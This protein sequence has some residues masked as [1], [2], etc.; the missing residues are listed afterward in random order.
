MRTGSLIA[1][2]GISSL[3][4]SG[5]AKLEKAEVV[6]S[7]GSG[8]SVTAGTT[9]TG[10]TGNTSG[11]ST[12]QSNANGATSFVFNDGAFVI[13]GGSKT[14]VTVT[15]SGGGINVETASVSVNTG[16]SEMSWAD[17]IEMALFRQTV[18]GINTDGISKGTNFWGGGGG[19]NPSFTGYKE[20][21][22]ITST[23][24][25]ELQ[26]WS[27]NHSSISQYTVFNDPSASNNNNVAVFFDGNATPTS[28]LPAG[29]ATY[30]GKF[31]GTAVASNWLSPERTVNDPFDTD[32]VIGETWDPNGTWRVVGDVSVTANFGAGTVNGSV[33]NTTWRKFTGTSTS[34]DGY[35]TITPQESARPFVNYTFNGTITDNTYSGNVQ[36]PAGQVVNG[37]NAVH[38]GFFGPNAE[39]TAGVIA[40][41]TTAPDP[42][43][44][45]SNNESNRRGYIT[46]RG[47]FQGTR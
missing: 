17:T 42:S 26:V 35:I 13:N 9:E 19:A 11:T 39:E 18:G 15:N 6:T 24:D 27:F 21:R 28:A 16:F 4:L 36:G 31:G 37:N 10:G 45:L 1:I 29:S 33:T 5:C 34:P 22:K 30:S 40:I 3:A 25:A 12:G 41:E 20:Y 47:V 43:D 44:G 38:G 23:T 8:E 7:T 32:G 2:L 46:L 14:E